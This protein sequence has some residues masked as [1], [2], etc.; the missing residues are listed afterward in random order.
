MTNPIYAFVR[1]IFKISYRKPTIYGVGNY[2]DSA[3]AVF[4]C[5]HEKFYGPILAQTRFPIKTRTWANSMTTETRVCNRYIAESLLIGEKG[6]KRFPAYLVGYLM[7]WFVSFI[8]RSSKPI[9]SYW[10]KKRSRKSVRA[11][12]ETI[13]RGENQLLFGRRKEFAGNEI[14]FMHGYRIICRIAARKYGIT[15]LL[16]P[17]AFNKEKATISIGRPTILDIEND[18]D[19]EFKRV[20]E[21]LLGKVRLGYEEPEKMAS[22]GL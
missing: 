13:L 18:S 3:P 14:R 2:D 6:W 22:A 15:P 19:I 8:I 7:G 12:V 17:V 4:M 20:D 16:Y 5:N 21:Y 11:G 9:I 1:Y 10:D